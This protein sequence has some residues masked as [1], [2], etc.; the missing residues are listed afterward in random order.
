M[1]LLNI[2]RN[3]AQKLLDNPSA[4][5]YF[6]KRKAYDQF[7]ADSY[8]PM[9]RELHFLSPEESLNY[10]IDNDSSIV[11]LGD[12]EFGLMRGASVYF[13]DW[14]QKFNKDLQRGLLGILASKSTN[15]IICLPGD[16][17]T[18]TKEELEKIG[19]GDEFNYWINSKVL[20]HKY[21]Q[22]DRVYGSSFA[23]YPAINTGINY[24]KLKEYFLK[25]NV[26]IVTSSLER[27]KDISLGKSTHLIEAPKSDGWDKLAEIRTA[28][29]ELVK[30]NNYLPEE[31]LVMVSMGPAAKVFVYELAE[32][33]YTAWDAGQFF[34]LAYKNIQA[35]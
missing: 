24:T 31:V 8:V 21:V 29:H 25:K 20:L 1:K 17:L 22:K 34:D 11:R 14:R 23:F 16:H 26:V 15:M 13:N 32:Q 3:R 19:K 35:L 28:F 5:F 18:K 4:I 10:I 33:G 30:K 9:Y 27:F 2:Y 12:G 7:T 6:V